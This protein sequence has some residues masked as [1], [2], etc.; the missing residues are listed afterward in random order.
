MGH[1]LLWV[2]FRKLA[3]VMMTM[4]VIGTQLVTLRIRLFLA[5]AITAVIALAACTTPRLIIDVLSA[6]HLGAD[7]RTDPD[8]CGNGLL[9]CSCLFQI[10]RAGRADQCMHLMACRSLASITT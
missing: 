4:P 7:R 6:G 1:E 8:W 9:R 3:V 10:H 5:M 2:L